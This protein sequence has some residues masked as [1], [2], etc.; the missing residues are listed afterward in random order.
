MADIFGMTIAFPELII[1]VAIFVLFL[2]ISKK[3]VKTV[4][5][6][7]WI[8]AASAAFPF[9]MRFLGFSFSTDINS[10]MF[11]V[12]LGL[13]LYFLY[14]LARIVYALLGAAEKSARFVAYPLRSAKKHKEEK[15]KKKVEKFVKEREKESKTKGKR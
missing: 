3:I 13:G 4:L 7:V 1:V 11:F 15:M 6:I 12:V 10:V 9:T 2:F 8:T 5:N 14:M